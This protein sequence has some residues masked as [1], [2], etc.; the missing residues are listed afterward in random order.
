MDKLPKIKLDK[1]KLKDSSYSRYNKSTKKYDVWDATT[2]YDEVKRLNLK[3]ITVPVA[4]LSLSFLPFTVDNLNDFI[5]QYTRVQNTDTKYPII[6]DNLGDIADGYHRLVK[7]IVSGKTTIKAYR[8]PEMP[9]KD[10]EEN[11]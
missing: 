5:F 9:K 11:E 4:S 3:P 10:R 8:L 1:L 7:T 2:L 6:I